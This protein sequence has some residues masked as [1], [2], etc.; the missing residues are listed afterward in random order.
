MSGTT[1]TKFYWADWLSDIGLR[2]CSIA[3]RGFWMDL[4]CVAASH[5]PCGYVASQGAALTTADMARIVGVSEPEAQAL[6]D[7]LDRNGVFSRD[8]SGRIYSRRMVKDA[9]FVQAARKFGH[10]GGNPNLRKS[11]EN[12]STLKGGVKP[13]DK[14]GDNAHIPIAKGHK[15][16]TGERLSF[17]PHGSIAFT[18]PWCSIIRESAPGKDVDEIAEAFRKWWRT[19]DNPWD[20]LG[21]ER[22]LATFCETHA[23][24]RKAA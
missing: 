16:Y 23:K 17:P 10:K 5:D 19:L 11:K 1:W 3:A 24:G 12:P 20:K 2:R 9:Q 7:E 8:K 13:A 6:L 15:T 14:G 18:E 4:L 21:I 22:S